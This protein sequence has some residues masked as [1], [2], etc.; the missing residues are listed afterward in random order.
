LV[1]GGSNVSA[2]DPDFAPQLDEE[3]SISRVLAEGDAPIAGHLGVLQEAFDHLAPEFGLL[4]LEGASQAGKVLLRQ[5]RVGLDAQIAHR[6]DN[7]A[8]RYFAQRLSTSTSS[9]KD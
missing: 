1:Y 6:F 2:R 4:G 9:G 8:D 7:R 3:H 5:S